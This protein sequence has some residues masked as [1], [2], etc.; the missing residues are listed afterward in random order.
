VRKHAIEIVAG[1]DSV[2]MDFT[3][4]LEAWRFGGGRD[5][6]RVEDDTRDVAAA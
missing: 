6:S 2:P 3:G 4:S 5:L 1:F